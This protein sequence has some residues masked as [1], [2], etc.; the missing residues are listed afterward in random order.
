MLAKLSLKAVLL[1][2]AAITGATGTLMVAGAWALDDLF[3]LPANLLW[4]S[5]VVLLVYVAG[6]VM[7]AR[8][9]SISHL[10]VELVAVTNVGWGIGCVALLLGDWTDANALGVGFILLQVI[11]VLAFAAL[12]MVKLR[13]AAAGTARMVQNAR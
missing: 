6:L 1:I 3:D 9:D 7:L 10:L 8:Q 12:Q 4:I 2:D 5:G 13:Q 11:A